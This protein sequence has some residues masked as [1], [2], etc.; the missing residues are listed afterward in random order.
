MKV[1]VAG[2]GEKP[3]VKEAVERTL[4]WLREKADVCGVELSRDVELA[5]RGAELVISFGGDGTMLSI[6]RRLRGEQTPVVGVNMGKVGFLAEVEHARAREG[7]EAILAG[8]C[9]ISERMM[10]VARSGGEEVTGLNDAVV[11][12]AGRPGIL[13]VEVRVGGERAIVF[14]GDGVIVSTPTG[15]TGYCLSAG[16]PI[17]AET[18]SCFVIVPL[19]AHSLSARPIVVGAEEPVEIVAGPEERRPSLVVDGQVTRELASSARV[20]VT[21]AEAPFRLVELTSA[22]R[23]E[24][25]RRKLRWAEDE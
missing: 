7:I 24:I 25:A 13:T 15:S 22:S 2:D 5:A 9:R 23:I 3:G 21:K 6:A 11:C 1:L 4:D 19:C 8:N 20:Q 18:L 12:R 10:L 14:S 16:G 17:V